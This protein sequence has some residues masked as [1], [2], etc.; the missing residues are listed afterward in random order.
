MIAQILGEGT[1]LIAIH[2]FGVDHRIML[3]L[4]DDLANRGWQRIYLDLPWAE[5]AADTG[6]RTPRELADAVLAE[7]RGTIGEAPFAVIGNS[8]GAMVARHLAHALP[9]QCLGLATLGG[10]FEPDRSRRICPDRQAVV[11][12]DEVLVRAGEARA[13]FEEMAVVQSEAALDAFLTSALPGLRGADQRVMGRIAAKY[14]H[15]YSPEAGAAEPFDAP[16]LHVFGRQ[17]HVVGFEDGLA[18]RDH[19]TRGAFVVLDAA[20]HNVHLE[21]PAVVG[22]LLRDWLDRTAVAR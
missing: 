16:S 9:A 8:F 3:P 4:D 14:T 19:Y 13:D 10:M 11:L 21:Q 12:D 17:D 22:A 7:V 1:P 5:G 2:G 6:E 20:G 18:L 15:A